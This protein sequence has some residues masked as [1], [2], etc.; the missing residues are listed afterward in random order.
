MDNLQ[1]NVHD[2][3]DHRE[4]ADAVF[5]NITRVRPLANEAAVVP[6]TAGAGWY[7]DAAIA[8]AE[9]EAIEARCNPYHH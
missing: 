3:A 2:I 5:A 9:R 6:T 7:H 1:S 8:D 4:D